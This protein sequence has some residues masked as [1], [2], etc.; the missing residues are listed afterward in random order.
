MILQKKVGLIIEE[1][2]TS[3][4]VYYKDGLELSNAESEFLD[5]KFVLILSCLT[6]NNIYVK[7][8][9]CRLIIQYMLTYLS[10]YKT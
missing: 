8:I 4:K 6:Y 1:R 5:C 9:I 2:N 7:F 3:Q 10:N